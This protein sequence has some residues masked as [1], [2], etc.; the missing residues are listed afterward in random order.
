MDDGWVSVYS[1]DQIYKAEIIKEILFDNQVISFVF[2]K[3]DSM[4]MFG[5]INICVK[6]ADVIR[7]KFVLKDIQL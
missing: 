2:N 6:P 5:E 1:T 3:K 4:Y 7:A